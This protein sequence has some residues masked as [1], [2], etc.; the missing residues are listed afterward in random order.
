MRGLKQNT[1]IWIRFIW[2]RTFN[3]FDRQGG[4]DFLCSNDSSSKG[5]WTHGIH[6]NL[7]IFF[8]R[9]IILT[10]EFFVIRNEIQRHWERYFDFWRLV[11][12]T[13]CITQIICSMNT[14]VHI[15]C[16]REIVVVLHTIKHLQMFCSREFATLIECCLCNWLWIVAMQQHQHQHS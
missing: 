4:R 12:C 7:R 1:F 14:R 16:S 2:D 9:D 3:A 10:G 6:T 13:P 8:L 5:R 15:Y 11:R